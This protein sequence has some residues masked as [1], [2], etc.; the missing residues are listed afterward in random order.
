VTAYLDTKI[1]AAEVGHIDALPICT[2][3]GWETVSTTASI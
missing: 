3:V 1:A 2:D